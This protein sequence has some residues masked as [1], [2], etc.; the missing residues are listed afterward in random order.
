LSASAYKPPSLSSREALLLAN[1]E[2]DR[3]LRLT[4]AEARKFAGKG[5]ADLLKGL[6]RKGVLHRIGRGVYLVKPLRQLARPSAFSS[7]VAVALL[8]EGQSYY[9]GGLWAFTYHQLST[10]QFASRI[11]VFTDRRRVSRILGAARVSFHVLSEHQRSYGIQ[12]EIMEGV[13]VRISDAERTLLDAL[14]QPKVVGGVGLALD[15][16][17]SALP[18][19]QTKR[20][21]AHAARGASTATCQRLGLLLERSGVAARELAPLRRRVR[22]SRSLLSM[23]PSEPRRGHVHPA[24]RVVENDG[25]GSKASG[26][27]RR[28]DRSS[29]RSA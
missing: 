22:E 7:I 15:F 26:A 27:L 20:L 21:V 8:M 5:T 14:D 9:V 2:R 28:P 29:R 11:D 18:Q 1:L 17:T 24:W 3:R 13:A 12:V 23:L 25:W 10:Q 19:V 16:V 6:V 4:L